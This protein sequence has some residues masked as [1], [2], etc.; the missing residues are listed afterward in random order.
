MT[1]QSEPLHAHEISPNDAA[2]IRMLS[3]ATFGPDAKVTLPS[4]KQVTGPEMARW[5]EP[6][7]PQAVV[8]RHAQFADEAARLADLAEARAARVVEL[9]REVVAMTEEMRTARLRQRARWWH[10][11]LPARLSDSLRPKDPNRP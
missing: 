4:G 10:R 8:Q 7:P 3:G 2:L 11:L 6:P 5:V 1:G 9:E